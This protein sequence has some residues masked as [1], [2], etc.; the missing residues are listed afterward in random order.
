MFAASYD[1]QQLSVADVVHVP[2]RST[3]SR[4]KSRIDADDAE[5]NARLLIDQL[6]LDFICRPREWLEN[7]R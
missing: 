4:K 5:N 2:R 1:A 6:P 7:H 3:A